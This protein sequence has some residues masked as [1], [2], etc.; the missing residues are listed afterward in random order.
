MSIKRKISGISSIKKM[1]S[2]SKGLKSETTEKSEYLELYILG[3]EKSRLEKE[4]LTLDG[5]KLDIQRRIDEISKQSEELQKSSKINEDKKNQII[6]ESGEK[7]W[8]KI[9]MSY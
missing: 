5:R 6:S 4:C 2:I 7:V 1:S 9:K 3:K 8:K